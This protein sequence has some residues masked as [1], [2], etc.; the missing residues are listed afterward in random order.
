MSQS[1]SRPVFPL[2][3]LIDSIDAG[4]P[5][6]EV[7]LDDLKR[8]WE[9]AGESLTC[10]KAIGAIGWDLIK[11]ALSP[12]ANVEAAF[13]RF[14]LL[15]A[16]FKQGEFAQWQ[17]GSQLDDAVFRAAATFAIDRTLNTFPGYAILNQLRKESDA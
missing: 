1:D 14:L 15:R 17:H 8:L 2:Q 10:E 13:L 5:L 3:S 11:Q 6:P 9:I 4:A 7:D 16:L 12:R